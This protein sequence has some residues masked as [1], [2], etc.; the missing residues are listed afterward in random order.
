[1]IR[2][3]YDQGVTFFDTAEVYGP[4][5]NE[6][7]VGEA[8]A[9]VRDKVKIATKFG[10]EID[11]TNGLDSRPERIRRVVEES[12]KRLRTDRIDLYLSA[13]RR[14]ER[15]DRGRRRHGQGPDPRRQG[16]AFRPIRAERPNHSPGPCRAAGRRYPDRI[17]PHRAQRRAQRRTRHLRGARHRLRPLGAA[18]ARLPAGQDEAGRPVV[19]GPEERP[20]RH[21]PALLADRDAEQSADH[22]LPGE[23]RRGATGDTRR[24]SHWPG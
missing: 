17:F 16:L 18:W 24:R 20:A 2:D 12:L 13:P 1:M 3:A 15:A 19:D 6:E 21:L 7:L 22:R 8:L 4:Y 5:V 11:G 10:F 14:P 9:P 23:V